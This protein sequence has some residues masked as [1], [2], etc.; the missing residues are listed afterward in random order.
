MKH[1]LLLTLL[2]V[3]L[4]EFADAYAE[5]G[6]LAGRVESKTAARTILAKCAVH[7]ANNADNCIGYQ[8]YYSESG[9]ESDAQAISNRVYTIESL[10]A[11]KKKPVVFNLFDTFLEGRESGFYTLDV[12]EY[13][14]NYEDSWGESVVAK[15]GYSMGRGLSYGLLIPIAASGDIVGTAVAAPVTLVQVAAKTIANGKIRKLIRALKSGEK[16]EMNI[17]RVY[18]LRDML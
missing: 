15:V 10:N 1:L 16:V 9:L 11:L 3:A 17:E 8:F 12:V 6:F 5:E 14:D 7:E 2:I 13:L 4:C 18:R